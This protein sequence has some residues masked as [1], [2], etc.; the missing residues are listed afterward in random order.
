MSVRSIR[1]LSTLLLLGG[2]AGAAWSDTGKHAA[3]QD[4]N[5]ITWFIPGKFAEARQ[6]AQ[7]QKRILMVK[8]IAFGIDA[9]GAKCATKGCW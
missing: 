1:F 2:L 3:C 8:G 4:T 9:V 6:A 5:N 7:T